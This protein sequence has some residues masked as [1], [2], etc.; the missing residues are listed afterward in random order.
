MAYE[1]AHAGWVWQS[2]PEGGRAVCRR[3]RPARPW[4]PNYCVNDAR[5]VA[6]GADVIGW[7]QEPEPERFA[8][9]YS[10]TLTMCPV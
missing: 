10:C 2:Q 1:A 7:T 4:F 8:I 6:L 9:A 3:I 5:A